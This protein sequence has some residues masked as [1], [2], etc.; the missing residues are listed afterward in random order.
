[1]DR[2]NNADHW[3]VSVTL[4]NRDG[5]II[6]LSRVPRMVIITGYVGNVVIEVAAHGSYRTLL[7]A[8]DFEE[9]INGGSTNLADFI[10]ASG[11][12]LQIALH[13]GAHTVPGVA[14]DPNSWKGDLVSGWLKSA[15][16]NRDR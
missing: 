12:Q 4:M 10:S 6:G 13:C 11:Q 1:L 2:A 3:D 8:R 7:N 15:S 5:K 9:V 16:P 14:V